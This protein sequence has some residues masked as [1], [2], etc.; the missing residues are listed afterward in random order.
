M[1]IHGSRR[2]PQIQ[3]VSAPVKCPHC[4]QYAPVL[5]VGCAEYYHV[6]WIPLFAWKT[7][8]YLCAACQKTLVEG[9]GY[10]GDLRVSISPD[11]KALAASTLPRVRLPWY[12]FIGLP[13]VVVLIFYVSIA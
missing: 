8:V 3:D 1:V 10:S 7:A 11:A 6:F 5:V 4:L 12:Y 13:A 2:V 9:R